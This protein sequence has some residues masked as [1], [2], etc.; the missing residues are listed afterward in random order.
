MKRAYLAR[1][2]VKLYLLV[3]RYNFKIDQT[4]GKVRLALLAFIYRF[5]G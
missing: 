3:Q 5:K 4:N 1:K 2:V